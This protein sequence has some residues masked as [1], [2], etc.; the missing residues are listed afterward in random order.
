MD[1]Q[2][3]L[4]AIKPAVI[5][6]TYP[7]NDVY[8]PT[9]TNTTNIT[10]STARP[11]QYVRVGRMVIVSGSVSITPTAT[12]A[13]LLL[14]SLPIASNFANNYELGGAGNTAPPPSPVL[15]RG[16]SVSDVAVFAFNA[17]STGAKEVYF[18]FTYQ[19]I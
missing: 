4:D 3:I 8:T 18:S 5:G 14:M 13:T 17:A 7:P 12:G 19:V 15:I 1:L 10:S 6:W 2:K 16:S 9:L 11:C